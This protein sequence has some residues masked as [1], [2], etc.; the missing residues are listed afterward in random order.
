MRDTERAGG[1]LKLAEQDLDAFDVLLKSDKIHDRTLGFHAQQA[2]EKSLKAWLALLGV[3]YPFTHDLDALFSL[4]EDSSVLLAH[5]F[6]DLQMLTPFAVQ[7]RYLTEEEAVCR[8]D[9][10]RVLQ[11]ASELV[12]FVKELAK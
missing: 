10:E 1:L 11:R 5:D 2:V 8:F 12:A 4:I 9:R 7:F 3:D 6:R